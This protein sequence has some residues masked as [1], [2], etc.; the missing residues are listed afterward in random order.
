MSAIYRVSGGVDTI[1]HGEILV[2][3]YFGRNSPKSAIS[4][5]FFP[6]Y[7]IVNASQ[8]AVK[9]ATVP[10]KTLLLGKGFE[11]QTFWFEVQIP[12]AANGRR[13][14]TVAHWLHCS[15]FD[16]YIARNSR[17]LEIYPEISLDRYFSM[18]YLV[19]TL[20]YTIFRRYI[21]EISRHFLPWLYIAL[22]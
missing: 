12:S 15:A 2:R 16:F 20:R 1:F 18:K 21:V 22:M 9:R 10:W 14:G 6:I 3:R 8:R 19:N 7:H 4:R 5:R 17:F 13:C 11:P